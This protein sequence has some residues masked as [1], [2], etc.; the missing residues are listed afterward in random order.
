MGKKRK[1]RIANLLAAALVIAF[2][3]AAV[4]A[5]TAPA[6]QAR[7]A[8]GNAYSTFARGPYGSFV[9]SQAAY[10]P[11]KLLP[12]GYTGAE[13]FAVC[14]EK[15][16]VADTAGKA[17][18]VYTAEGAPIKSYGLRPGENGETPDGTF[19]SPFGVTVKD[20]VLYVADK[21]K[22]AVVRIN[23][24]DGTLIDEIGKPDSPLYGAATPFVP[25]KIAV[26]DAHNIYVTGEGCPNGVIH[27]NKDGGFEGFLG[28]NKTPATFMSVIQNIFFS[29]AQKERLLKKVPP[30]PNAVALDDR[31]LLY[32]VT[33]D[34][35]KGAVKRLNTSGN[36]IADSGKWFAGAVAVGVDD[37]YNMYSVTNDGNIVIY[38]E[39]GH[40]L[41][42]FGGSDALD[43]FGRLVNPTAIA[44]TDTLD[45]YVLDKETGALIRYRPTDF[46]LLVH[47]ALRLYQN[48]FY[49]EAEPL[50]TEVL[51]ANS[52]FI[53]GY[54]SL[55][56]A[57]IKHENYSTALKQFRMAEDGDGYSEAF[58]QIRNIWLQNNILWLILS[59]AALIL[60]IAALVQI[61]KRTTWL[62][63][64]GNF[65]G[66]IKKN[67]IVSQL[68]YSTYYMR[69]P[70]TAIEQMRYKN[71]L[72]VLP[73]CIMYLLYLAV[74]V[75]G[76][77]FIG[78]MWV[79]DVFGVRLFQNIMIALLPL[80]LGVVCNY[81][82]SSVTNGAGKFSHVFIAAIYSFTPYIL[83]RPIFI[84]LTNVLTYNEMVIL[85]F[86]NYFIIAYC[87]I[88]LI[89]SIYQVHY[90]G[91]KGTIKNVLLT[92]FCFV[93]VVIFAVIIYLLVMQQFGFWESLIWEVFN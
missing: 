65:F 3:A 89:V 72:T 20:G 54:R 23:E 10:D 90:Y 93:M 37:D 80:L 34:A 79:G 35:A 59:V 11:E 21:G 76:V 50:W 15:L 48:G 28:A 33:T 27:I 71:K 18:R 78:Y 66:K 92:A 39:E 13:D 6:T 47:E 55:A 44:V 43:R 64:V 49:V 70:I 45:I 83:F 12:L 2:S 51:A 82:V 56:R 36:V 32:T 85:D 40:L 8:S 62:A 24:A 4:S 58:W 61:R 88:L 53:E 63:P 25:T 42:Q 7:A 73:A 69:H 5:F 68:L 67:R 52:G 1:N 22:Q 16:Y 81:F 57:N 46:Y 75:F 19:S 14:G 9:Q 29:E 41:F 91:I 38:T 17:V 30:S 86:I 84:L 77:F 31:G 87:V 74:S 60:V 26:D